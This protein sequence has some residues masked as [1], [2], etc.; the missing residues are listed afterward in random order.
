M[1]KNIISVIKTM[2]IERIF[3]VLSAIIL[4]FCFVGVLFS[5]LD[6][7]TLVIACFYAC[8]WVLALM[9]I[10][11]LVGVIKSMKKKTT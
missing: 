2:N 11:A 4:A 6:I 5:F 8:E 1:T 7:G 9:V 10:V 3:N